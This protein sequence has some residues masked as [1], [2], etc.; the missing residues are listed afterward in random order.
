MEE[1]LKIEIEIDPELVQFQDAQK[2]LASQGKHFYGKV[3]RKIPYSQLHLCCIGSAGL[4]AC[5]P[6]LVSREKERRIG[7]FVSLGPEELVQAEGWLKTEGMFSDVM[8]EVTSKSS[9][10]WQDLKPRHKVVAKLF[11][12]YNHMDFPEGRILETM[13]YLKQ[14][15]FDGLPPMLCSEISSKLLLLVRRYRGIGISEKEHIGDPEFR[16]GVWKVMETVMDIL[17][18]EE[19]EIL[20]KEQIKDYSCTQGCFTLTF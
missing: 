19:R 20:L 17:P 9:P 14:A 7:R 15:A 18:K 1:P 5:S 16:E 12:I 3:L 8:A 11:C 4:T 6:F 10:C 13:E 2:E